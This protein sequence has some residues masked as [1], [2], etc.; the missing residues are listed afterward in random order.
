M[1]PGTVWAISSNTFREN[2]RDRVLYVL[3]F[4]AGALILTSV[5]VGELSPFEQS[6]ILLDFGQSVMALFGGLIA[7]FLGIGLVSREIERRTVYVVI[8]KPVSRIEFLAGK[9]LGLVLTLTTAHVIMALTLVTVTWAY[10]ARPTVALAQ[11][12]LLIWS[13]LV[14]VTA[15]AVTFASF[16]STNLAAMFT[17]GC[18]A[19]GQMIGDLQEV[20]H[21]SGNLLTRGVLEGLYWVLPNLAFFDVKSRATYGIRVPAP[22]MLWSLGYGATYTLLLLGI[23]AWVFSRRDFR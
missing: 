23:A 7:V 4:F 11:S 1:T 9:V 10:G 2:R 20:A 16:S 21:R 12:V 14:L 5:V 8:S 22:E 15:M 13:E 6:K 18:W 19:I 3:V 17:L